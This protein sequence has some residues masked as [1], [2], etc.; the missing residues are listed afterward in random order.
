MQIGVTAMFKQRFLSQAPSAATLRGVI[1]L[2]ML[3]LLSGGPSL[4]YE[5]RLQ[6]IPLSNS[7]GTKAYSVTPQQFEELVDR[8]NNVYAGTGIHFLFD[9][10]TDWAPMNDTDLNTDGSDQQVRG[11]AIAA[12]YPHKILLLLRWGNDPNPDP[13]QP[14]GLQPTGNGNAY[15]P[16]RNN[17]PPSVQDQTQNYVALPSTYDNLNQDAGTG[18]FMAHELGHYLGLYHTFPGWTD[19]KG[20][21]YAQFNGVQPSVSDANQAVIEYIDQNGG[22]MPRST[23]TRS[24]IR[25]PTPRLSST[26]RMARISSAL[27]K[28]LR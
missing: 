9:Q 2:S 18:S 19:L 7:D 11:N 8:V 4:A 22:T 15:P 14:S 26:Q 28:Q 3:M 12:M 10:Y 27:N 17:P 13:S 20:P 16:P 25:L 6:V 23:G 1:G 5:L 24:L 21:V